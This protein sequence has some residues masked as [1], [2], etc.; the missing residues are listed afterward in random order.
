[1]TGNATPPRLARSGLM[2]AV[3][4]V[5]AVGLYAWQ[6]DRLYLVHDEVIY[7][8]NA[9]AIAT[10]WRD[11]SGQFLPISFPVVG[12]FF[13][14]PMNIYF[15]ALFLKV[16]PLTEVVV[17]LPSVVIGVAG[18]G[19]VFLI[20][21]R[22]FKKDSLAALAAGMLALTPAHFIH[23]R[24]GTDHL[25]TVVLMLGWLLCLLDVKSERQVLR[26]GMASAL[27]GL[28]VYSYLGALITMPV[29]FVITIATLYRMGFRTRAPYLAAVIG[30]GVA[31]L[32]FVAWHLLHPDQYARQMQMYGLYNSA[33]VSPAE[34]AR[35]LASYASVADRVGVYWDY[36]NPSLLFFAGDTGL[37]NGTRYAGV[38]LW[39]L[40][41]LL[42][43][44]VYRLLVQQRS[45]AGWL[46][47][48]GLAASPLAATVV[49]ERYRINRALVMLP[50]A[51]LVATAG[52]EMMWA[53]RQR[54][55][56]ACAIVLLAAMPVQFAGFYQDY[57]VAYPGRSYSWFEYNIRGGMEDVIARQE[58]LAPVFIANNI[59]WAD[60]YWPFY[61]AK[62]GRQDLRARTSYLDVSAPGAAA[63]VPP[64]GV[65]LCRVADA[66]AMKAAGLREVRAITEPDGSQSFSV[67]QR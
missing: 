13:A 16:A 66:A 48:V 58:G 61:L 18:I 15:T 37:I 46:L 45:T 5:T 20:G 38:F 10:T 19:L 59:Q 62:L 39:P 65:L 34:G 26:I 29:C 51:A 31:V 54:I 9:H 25:Y 7:A 27:L 63:S 57:F 23:S 47:I 32:P 22:V 53:S 49:A 21:R 28:G 3:I 1:M 43:A 64:G 24:L 56:R 50:L 36:F 42:P 44:G 33:R 17:R 52:V 40:M 14:T 4:L 6:L 8:L 30:A 55:W 67:M 12:T 41:V 35:Q 11:L 60:Y 2:M